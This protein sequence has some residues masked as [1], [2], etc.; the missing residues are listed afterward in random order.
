[1]VEG[2]ARE[3]FGALVATWQA[4]HVTDAE[5]SRTLATIAE[6]ETRHAALSWAIARWSLTRLDSGARARLE[7]AWRAALDQVVRG[8]DLAAVAG[9]PSREERAALASELQGLWTDLAA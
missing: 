4:T 2:C 9:L 7:R 6:D 5:T 1:V 8:D 3:T